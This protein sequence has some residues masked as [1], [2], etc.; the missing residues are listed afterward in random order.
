MEE[1]K[2]IL[3]AVIFVLLSVSLVSAGSEEISNAGVKYDLKILDNFNLTNIEKE[4]F[5]QGN[6]EA[7]PK[8]E[9]EWVYVTIYVKDFSNVA[10]DYNKDSMDT[11]ITKDN[12]KWIVYRATSETILST[13]SMDEFQLRRKSNFGIS[14]SGNITKRGLAK[15]LEDQRVRKIYAKKEFEKFLDGSA[16]IINADDVWS[17]YNGTGQTICVVDGGVNYTRSDLG[18]CLGSGCKVVSGYDYIDLDSDPM[19]E[20][21][22]NHGT[23]MAQ[24]ASSSHTTYKGIANGAKIVALRACGDESCND[25]DISDSLLWCYNNRD[26]YNISVVSM[27]LGINPIFSECSEDYLDSEIGDLTVAGIP[28]IAASG[29]D[30]DENEIAYPACNSDTISVGATYN[31]GDGNTE[32]NWCE[33]VHGG[34]LIGGVCWVG[35]N[36]TYQFSCAD[37]PEVDEIACFTNRDENLDLLAPGCLISTA[38]SSEYSCGTSAATPMVAGAA[39]LLLEKDPTLSPTE[40]RDREF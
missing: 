38:G 15:L 28:V 8:K 4:H 40:I 30:D 21:V 3:F 10:I 33:L 12:Q 16:L 13:L 20:D 27:S 35:L 7:I 26:T 18:G 14:I 11:Q 31:F 36:P 2:I 5:R 25:Q 9:N 29:N 1:K 24:I 32:Y 22:S 23:I 37:Y 19:D 34:A 6:L 17:S 39:A